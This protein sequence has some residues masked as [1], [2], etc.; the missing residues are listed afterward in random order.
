MIR[1]KI[2]RRQSFVSGFARIKD[3]GKDSGFDSGEARNKALPE[4]L[5]RA[6][7]ESKP[8]AKL[9]RHG[10]TMMWASPTQLSDGRKATTSWFHH[11]PGKNRTL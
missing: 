11:D 5:L 10:F 3:L 4:T 2:C 6:K 1:A 7:P 8:E 9:E